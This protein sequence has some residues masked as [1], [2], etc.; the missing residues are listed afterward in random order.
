MVYI[1][2]LCIC[3]D[4]TIT[5]W[6][7]ESGDSSDEYVLEKIKGFDSDLIVLCECSP[8][9]YKKI[10]GPKVCGITGGSDRIACIGNIIRYAE[11]SYMSFKGRA[12]LIVWPGNL[13]YPLCFVHLYSSKPELRVAQTKMLAEWSKTY[14]KLAIIG[15]FNYFDRNTGYNYLSG[16][17]KP[18]VPFEKTHKGGTPD[19]S[20]YKGLNLTCWAIMEPL[21]DGPELPDHRP[22]EVKIESE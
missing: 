3:S 8:T 10:P 6:N 18:C 17:L 12:P 1:L 14:A 19:M 16:Y 11:L 21:T 22:I 9:L 15:D 7:V 4:Y 13:K 20:F 2:L 5:F